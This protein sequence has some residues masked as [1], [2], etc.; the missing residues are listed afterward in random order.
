MDQKQV[1]ELKSHHKN[2]ST[3][4][5]VSVLQLSQKHLEGVTKSTNL[6]VFLLYKIQWHSQVQLQF[7]I[8]TQGD[9]N[10][11]TALVS[12]KI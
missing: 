5:S 4:F 11:I 9:I 8:K 12:D 2:D 3:G 6:F 7:S 10:Y 1:A